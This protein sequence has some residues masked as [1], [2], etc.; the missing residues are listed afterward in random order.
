MAGLGGDWGRLS[1]GKQITRPEAQSGHRVYE[2]RDQWSRTKGSNSEGVGG[3]PITVIASLWQDSTFSFIHRHVGHGKEFRPSVL[4][5]RSPSEITF[6]RFLAAICLLPHFCLWNTLYSFSIW[7][8]VH[9][10]EALEEAMWQ[11]W[12]YHRPPRLTRSA[13][14]TP[15]FPGGPSPSCEAG[16][17]PETLLSL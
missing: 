11:A 9:L 17:S 1:K 5:L 8:T 12:G 13:S 14:D 2:S 3:P 4:T 15:F 6:G 10:S 7:G 16:G